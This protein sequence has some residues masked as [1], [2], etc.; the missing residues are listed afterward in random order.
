MLR[1]L[2][3]GLACGWLGGVGWAC[4][5]YVPL[6]PPAP[7]P[8]SSLA[9]EL[10]DSGTDVLGR[11]LGPNVALVDGRLLSVTP[12]SLALSVRSVTDREGIDH[13]WRGET[14]SLPRRLVATL[15]RRRLSVG[16]TTVFAAGAALGAV[17]VLRA[18]G[19]ISSGSSSSMPPPA[20]Q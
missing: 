1:R 17:L 10:T 14:V 6:A 19:V 12:D 5:N 4:Y 2:V 13:F 8:G 11:Y 18:F 7:A 15:S 20:G 3:S 16:R 9:V